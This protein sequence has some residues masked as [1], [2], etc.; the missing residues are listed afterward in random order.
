M[1][2]DLHD[3]PEHIPTLAAWHHQEWGHLNPGGSLATRIEKMQ[4]YLSGK[5]IPKMLVWIDAQAVIGSAGILPCDMDTKPELT[6]W[7]ASVFV[8]PEE[9]SKGIGSLLV[10]GVMN[11]AAQHGFSELF[12]FTPDQEAFY[13]K[14]G[15][16]TISREEYRGVHVSVM[17]VDLTGDVQ[18]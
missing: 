2:V 13:Q 17:R 1:I 8:K 12:L 15:W 10:K 7:L 14:L 9:R 16:K 4:E 5:P 6:P 18:V 11:Y 3:K